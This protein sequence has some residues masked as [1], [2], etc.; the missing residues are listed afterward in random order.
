MKKRSVKDAIA[1]VCHAVGRGRKIEKKIEKDMEE[2]EKLIENVPPPDPETEDTLRLEEEEKDKTRK[3]WAD[4]AKQHKLYLTDVKNPGLTFQ[5][6]IADTVVI[7]RK[8]GE[9]DLVIDYE[10]SVSGKHC[11]ISERDGKFYVKDLQ[12]ANGSLLNGI[13][14]SEEMEIYSGSILTLGRLRVKV[15]IR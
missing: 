3:I 11:Q 5:A 6:P 9:A 14:L 7:G 15:Q 10:K 4:E 13:R 8:K 2:F 12:S 1:E